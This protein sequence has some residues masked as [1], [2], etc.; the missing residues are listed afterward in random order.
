ML[1]N[2]KREA[3]EPSLKSNLIIVFTAEEEHI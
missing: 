3:K 1:K 2:T